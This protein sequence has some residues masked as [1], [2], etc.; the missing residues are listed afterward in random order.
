[1][2]TQKD[3]DR[4]NRERTDKIRVAQAANL[5]FATWHQPSRNPLDA[6]NEA[7]LIEDI[8]WAYDLLNKAEAKILGTGPEAKAI[9]ETTFKPKI[10]AMDPNVLAD[11]KAKAKEIGKKKGLIF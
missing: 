3:W 8:N 1:M 5:V 7:K 10:P 11:T 2:E 9:P 4:I 6:E